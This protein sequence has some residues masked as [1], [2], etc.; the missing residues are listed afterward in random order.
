MRN[1]S[2]TGFN[3]YARVFQSDNII[4]VYDW[5]VINWVTV[6]WN[7]KPM[8]VKKSVCF[9]GKHSSQLI[10]LTLMAKY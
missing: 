10:E 1:A 3:N 9:V 4:S 7:A 2:W 8:G 5:S 6:L